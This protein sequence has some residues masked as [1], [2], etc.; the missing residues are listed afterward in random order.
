MAHG[1]GLTIEELL[2]ILRARK[3]KLPF[4]V[5]AF[6]A[7]QICELLLEAP[8]VVGAADVVVLEDGKVSLLDVSRR[9]TPEQ[10]AA[11]LH[12]ILKQL[13]LAAGGE[14]APML[15]SVVEAR[16]PEGEWGLARLRDELEASLLPLNRAASRR[17]LARLLRE[18]ER[19]AAN[20][21]SRSQS[22]REEDLDADLDALFGGGDASRTS[23]GALGAE[24][25]PSSPGVLSSPGILPAEKIPTSPGV[26]PAARVSSSGQ[27]VAERVPSS[28][29]TITSPGTWSSPGT[30][31]AP[32]VGGERVSYAERAVTRSDRPSARASTPPPAPKAASVFR[33]ASEDELVPT[34][35]RGPDLH[36]I[37]PK[38]DRS[39]LI[40]LLGVVAL[41][42]A[43]AGAV[44]TL[45][46]DLVQRLRGQGLD[47]GVAAA[48]APSVATRPSRP[49]GDVVIRVATEGAQI[50]LFVGRGPATVER[51]PVGVA[52]EFVVVA[53]GREPARSVVP[54]DAT[55]PTGPTGP[56]Y[57]LAIMAGP[58]RSGSP[59]AALGPSQLS[60]DSMGAP[61]GTLGNVRIITNPPSSKVFMTIGFAPEARVE[62][63]PID[64]AHEL[65]VHA[66]GFESQRV[67]LGPS[68]FVD[69]GGT[70]V[71]TVDVTLE[72]SR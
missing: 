55:W 27:V 35:S 38:R 3:D 40:T 62:H 57:E 10:A 6:L 25:M 28:P 15:L 59:S 18:T 16:Q 37:P 22:V 36:S 48:P 24:R 54:S 19:D 33:D 47:A 44:A 23:P 21:G 50:L 65:L 46:P 49:S 56:T 4:E 70:K 7:L 67:V 42:A 31:E 39:G 12:G 41:L 30:V 45:R 72:R 1:G 63:L 51:L 9:S 43:F 17:V 60:S 2:S 11:G 64:E 26:V 8:V 5:G 29:G 58:P 20:V 13:L 34:S 61:N 32:D 14:V 53:D 66:P 69:V 71:A 68:D 52:H